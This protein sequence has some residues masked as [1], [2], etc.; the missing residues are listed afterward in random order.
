MGA[1]FS[2]LDELLRH[3]FAY[4]CNPK[5]AGGAQYQLRSLRLN[6]ELLR[7]YGGMQGGKGMTCHVAPQPEQPGQSLCRL[8]GGMGWFQSSPQV[9][10]QSAG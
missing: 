5:A 8:S 10:A 7:I 1:P 6:R 9:V 4:S 2:L 3:G